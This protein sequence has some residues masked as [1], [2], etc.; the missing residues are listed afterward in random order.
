MRKGQLNTSGQ[1]SNRN[2]NCVTL[3][4]HQKTWRVSICAS[5]NSSTTTLF[6]N[7]FIFAKYNFFSQ[8]GGGHNSFLK[9]TNVDMNEMFTSCQ[10]V[11]LGKFN[12]VYT[13]ITLKT[14]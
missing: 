9:I 2:Q 11:K 5:T 3:T 8:G 4:N 14:V 10:A 6:A 7:I 1:R 12:H 13:Q